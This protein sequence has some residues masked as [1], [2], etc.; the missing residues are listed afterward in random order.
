MSLACPPFPW[1][2][3]RLRLASAGAIIDSPNSQR[4]GGR[5]E[6]GDMRRSAAR[7]KGVPVGGASR[8]D[9]QMSVRPGAGALGDG[10]KRRFCQYDARDTS[11]PRLHIRHWRDRLRGRGGGARRRRLEVRA[12]SARLQSAQEL[13]AAGDDA[14]SRRRRQPLG[15]IFARAPALPPVLS[16]SGSGQGSFHLRRRQEFLFARRVRPRRHRARRHRFPAGLTARPGRLD[17]HPTG[18]EEL[19][20]EFGSHV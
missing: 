13:R 10:R 8:A 19:P 4:I 5:L 18:G 16:H 11:P 1:L 20:S 15:G 6:F 14:R 3:G 7:A 17:H 9:R 2:T 12:G